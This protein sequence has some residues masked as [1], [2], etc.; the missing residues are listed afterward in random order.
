MIGGQIEFYDE[1]TAWGLIRGDDGHLYDL[2]SS[3]VSGAPPSVGDK[4]V[5]EPQATPGGRRASSVRRVPPAVTGPARNPVP[6][7]VSGP[8]PRPVVKA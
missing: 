6:P 5:F 3:H 1:A 4:V 7:T 8:A 2:R